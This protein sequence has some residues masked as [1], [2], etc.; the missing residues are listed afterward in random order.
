MNNQ[1]NGYYFDA[2]DESEHQRDS[3]MRLLQSQNSH[4]QQ[5]LNSSQ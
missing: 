2:D 1:Q 5:K 4:N 3:Y